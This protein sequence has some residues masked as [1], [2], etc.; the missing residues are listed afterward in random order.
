[1]RSRITFCLFIIAFVSLNG[2]VN[3]TEEKTN[4]LFESWR[5]KTFS[6]LGD[7][8]VRCIAEGK[9]QSLWFGTARGLYHYDGLHWKNY[10]EENE[11]LK[12]PVYA[13]CYTSSDILYA[14]STKGICHL[15]KGN[16]STDILFPKTG[17]L[18]S[19]WEILNLIE[20][21]NGEIW[22]G[23]YFGVIKIKNNKITLFSTSSQLSG[24]RDSFNE[25]DIQDVTGVYAG[26]ESLIVFDM[27]EDKSG[28]LWIGLEDGRTLRLYNK[29]HNL[30]SPGNY[31]LYSVIDGLNLSR[32]PLLYE[33]KAGLIY[34][35]SQSV[36]GAVNTFDP[37]SESWSSH[38]LS[39]DFGGDNINFSICETP[40]GI[41][42]IGGFSRIF[43]FWKDTWYEYK[44]PL[45]QIPPTRIIF[46]PAS[47]GSLWMIGHQ[48]DVI[49][50]EYQTTLWTTYKNLLFQCETVD[51]KQWFI[52]GEGKVVSFDTK[53][54]TWEMLDEEFPLSDPTRI[55]I[56]RSNVLW[57][58]GS[59]NGVA[60]LAWNSGGSWN[61]KIFP[62]LCWGFH[63][64]GIFQSKDNSIWFGANAD[65]GDATWGIVRYT[66]SK[67]TMDSENAWQIY[68]GTQVCE[69]AYALG[70][71]D[72]NS[73]LCGFYKGLFEYNGTQVR[74][75]HQVLLNDIIKVESMVQDPV[76]GV[77]IGTRSQGVI[78]YIN[79][80]DWTQYTVENGLASNSISS[81]I[82]SDDSTL[83][84]AT[85]KGISRFDGKK[86][87]KLA[88]PEYFKILRGN[89]SLEKGTNNSIWINI[90]SIEWYRRVFYKK[91]FTTTN[92]PLISYKIQ[93]E[94]ITPET[95]ITKCDRKVFYPGNAMIAWQGVDRWNDT[96]PSELQYSFKLD[97][98]EWSDF[99]T[100]TTHTFLSMNRGRHK[101]EVRARDN[102]MNIDPVPATAEFKI[103]PPVWGQAW[104]LLLIAG[105]IATIVYL[106]TASL[107]KNREMEAQN[108]VMQQ[109][110]DDL[111]KQ[112]AEIEEKSKQIMVLL[113]KERESHWFNEGVIAINDIIKSNRDNLVSLS[114]SL[115]A[116][117]I[118]YLDVHSAGIMLYHKSET[119]ET[120]GYLE[121]LSAYG[122]NKER[123]TN[124][125]IMQEEGLA[126][127]CFKEKKTMVFR[128]I[129]PTYFI[130]SGMGKAKIT[131]L[132]L[133]PLKLH[134]EIVGII[135]VS[136]FHTIDEKRIRLLEIVAENVASNIISLDAKATIEELYKQSQ[137]NSARL[138]EQEEELHQ[139]MEELQA[140]QEESHRREQHLIADLEECRKKKGKIKK[141]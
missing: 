56:D 70:E 45:I 121:L 49:R 125:K 82:F 89:G 86:W 73:L 55:Y 92:S 83:W 31:T 97:E 133:V 15:S 1:M 75:L 60:A 91:E 3:Y 42:W 135:E 69:V 13:L 6:E 40:D 68:K 35:I 119:E 107:K 4:P 24:I 137:E 47:D 53:F 101:I 104:F 99:T 2:S 48:A 127:A 113:E 9:D 76:K 62:D 46:K 80:D 27:I 139:Q 87:N 72:N 67:G 90:S 23:L 117:F 41:L 54:L 37:A 81:L 65:C 43:A 118:E 33:S 108:L 21:S 10:F 105:F 26:V 93:P 136:S 12:A 8:A 130:E 94:Q 134:D 98:E 71:T 57:A 78:H 32:L 7:K 106:F 79:D 131:E 59:H 124:K 141:E 34:N 51:G 5:W 111:V 66:P 109:K 115:T 122:Y 52:S 58:I 103:I 126:G 64:N 102:F 77:W 14:V 11:V 44:Q 38:A 22:I 123:L 30:K 140:T 88:L 74:E 20:T 95:E 85:D 120:G 129:P 128:N 36:G 132:V 29:N 138:H 110:N 63:S 25:I 116:K 16:W 100:E 28:N 39:D 96:K 18:G 19:E 112:Q 84:V 114:H 17:V 50:I 61:L